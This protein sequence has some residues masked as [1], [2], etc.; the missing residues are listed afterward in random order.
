MKQILSILLLALLVTTSC[1]RRVECSEQNVTVSIDPVFEQ[2]NAT[3]ATATAFSQ[4][5]Q[6][7]LYVTRAGQELQRNGNLTDNAEFVVNSGVIGGNPPLYYPDHSSL[8]NL[9][10]YY[11]YQSGLANALE[12]FFGIRTGQADISSYV[13][14][15][16]C[17]G[18]A[19]DVR[20]AAT[21]QPIT[22]AHSLSQLNFE[23]T[24]PATVGGNAV[25]SVSSIRLLGMIDSVTLNL[26]SGQVVA[27]SNRTEVSMY[28]QGAKS[29]S[30]IVPAQELRAGTLSVITLT[31][32]DN[33]TR[34]YVF[35]LLTPISITNGSSNKFNVVI[36]DR[37]TV[38]LNGQ[39]SITPWIES[40]SSA[41]V[42]EP[43]NNE[44]TLLWRLPNRNYELVSSVTLKIL[45]PV[46]Q[47]TRDFNTT[48]FSLVRDKS[49]S[50]FCVYKFNITIP[51]GEG[52]SY[53]YRVSAIRFMDAS[54]ELIQQCDAVVAATIT[55]AGAFTMGIEQ[56]Y[57]MHIK[58]GT[59]NN[60]A[61]VV[62]SGSI[63]GGVANSFLIKLIEPAFDFVG[64]LNNVRLRIDGVDYTFS[65]VSSSGNALIETTSSFAFPDFNN[66][67]PPIYPYVIEQIGLRKVDNSEIQTFD[68]NIMVTRGGPITLQVFRGVV[69]VITSSVNGYGSAVGTGVVDYT[70]PVTSNKFSVVYCAGE[71][72]PA[73]A[74][75]KVQKLRMT[76]N[77]SSIV[78]LGT[79]TMSGTQF[80]A[81]ST[82]SVDITT[83]S[84]GVPANYPYFINKVEY[85]DGN[86]NALTTAVLAEPI[87]I[88]RAG[89]IVIR[90]ME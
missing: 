21:A 36:D 74:C 63:G 87:K 19:K 43:I 81:T 66:R 77:G 35:N 60:W 75:T 25:S 17:Y 37:G 70:G 10:S 6:L 16:L 86:G 44:F 90:V 85:L 4:G 1:Q 72:T 52:I 8:V 61:D 53:P 9:Y 54:G 71:A 40:N 33:S 80:A 55:R 23:V 20:P 84:T 89:E 12:V 31:M 46:S 48:N 76:I 32:A 88:V 50:T 79:Y 2:S 45:D 82:T 3:K 67:V 18:A 83:L 29:F 28:K 57:I 62:G 59:V 42:T 38:L 41:T 7:G 34:D 14:S 51:L 47:L 56:A 15:D 27:G 49:S 65:P 30:A 26:S 69:I 13:A 73:T 39:P 5:D 68:A 64:A 24:A 78:T 22:Y 58:E 11:P